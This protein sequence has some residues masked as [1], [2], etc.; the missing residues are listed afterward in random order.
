MHK[1]SGVFRMR[2]RGRPDPLASPF[3]HSKYA[4]EL[5]EGVIAITYL[6]YPFY[7]LCT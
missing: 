6:L 2:E 4:T 1:F 7:A 5:R 3:A